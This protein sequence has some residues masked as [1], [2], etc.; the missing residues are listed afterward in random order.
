[1]VK[2]ASLEFRLR[3]IDETRN[4]LLDEI[5]HYNLKS[6]KYKKT[7]KYINY[8]ENLLILS[9]TITGCVSIFAFSLLVGTN[10]GITS[11]SV[12]ISICAIIVGIKKHKSMIKKKKSMIK[13]HCW[14][15]IN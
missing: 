15:K 14:E 5:K 6:E 13:Q 12:G 2:E 3:K 4:H 7:Y 1:M 10:V 11:S 8:V 9:S